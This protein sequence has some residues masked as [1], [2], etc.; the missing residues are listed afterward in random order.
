M[1]DFG[2]EE[3]GEI[4]FKKGD[5]LIVTDKPDPN[6][7]VGY[8]EGKASQGHFPSTYVEMLRH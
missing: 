2:A 8:I 1:F 7:W 5:V 3:E 4:S 6:W